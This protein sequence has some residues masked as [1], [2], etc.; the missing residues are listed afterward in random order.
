MPAPMARRYLLQPLPAP[1]PGR[2]HGPVA[3]HLGTV[4]RVMPGDEVILHDGQGSQCTAQVTARQGRDLLVTIG[5]HRRQPRPRPEIH[6][7]VAPPR[8]N[9]AEWLFEHGT[10]VGTAVFHPLGTGR[11]RPQGDKASRWRRQCEAAAGQCDRA[12]VP[13]VHEPRAL[14][15]FLQ[16]PTLPAERYLADPSG[17][18]LGPAA[19]DAAVLLV[20]PEGGFAPDERQAA[21]A[22]GFRPAA[23]GPFVLR[24]ETA[25]VVGAAILYGMGRQ[26]SSANE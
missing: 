16:D 19:T 21:L 20:G 22:A 6:L 4:L 2:L 1:G 11:S 15:D 14:Q 25:A 5:P 7:A 9:R 23:L 17:P 10:E 3:H 12:W 18:P 13:L 26:T 24:T 8:W